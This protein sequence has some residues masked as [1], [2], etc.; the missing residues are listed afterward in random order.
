MGIAAADNFASQLDHGD[1]LG[2]FHPLIALQQLRPQLHESGYSRTTS[3]GTGS[4]G[5]FTDM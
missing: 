1:S 4:L 2:E 5:V 3:P